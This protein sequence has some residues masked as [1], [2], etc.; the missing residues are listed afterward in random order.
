MW[1]E[2]ENRCGEEAL[3]QIPASILPG[4]M[5]VGD[6][7][8]HCMIPTTRGARWKAIGRNFEEKSGSSDSD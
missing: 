4:C 7:G 1:W 5:M 6:I 8:C 3:K 2:A